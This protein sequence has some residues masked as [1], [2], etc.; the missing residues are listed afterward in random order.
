MKAIDFLKSKSDL[1]LAALNHFDGDDDVKTPYLEIIS[2]HIEELKIENYESG[3]SYV[4]EHQKIK[5]KL[6]NHQ[7]ENTE[8]TRDL[9]DLMI[10]MIT[11]VFIENEKKG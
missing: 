9:N 2:Y 10:D 3:H 8:R 5:F 6:I 4:T 11:I 1:M 7:G